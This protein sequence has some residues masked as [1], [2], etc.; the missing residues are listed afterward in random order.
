MV[1]VSQ[2]W[3]AARHE[4]DLRFDAIPARAEAWKLSDGRAVN[5][6]NMLRCSGR[7]SIRIYN[8]YN[9]YIRIYIFA[10]M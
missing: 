9:I 7:C 4:Y 3:T 8:R 5:K 2:V 6:L 1:F 10:Y